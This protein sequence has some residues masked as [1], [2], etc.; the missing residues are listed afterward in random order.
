MSLNKDELDVEKQEFLDSIGEY[1]L[2]SDSINIAFSI[3][4]LFLFGKYQ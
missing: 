1:G 2:F 3:P 4:I